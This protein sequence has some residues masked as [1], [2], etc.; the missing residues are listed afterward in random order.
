VA[1]RTPNTSDAL[2]LITV[3]CIAG[4]PFESAG[5][6]AERLYMADWRIERWMAPFHDLL[7]DDK[8]GA[9]TQLLL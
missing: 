9:I 7:F 6:S 5:Q 3:L 8:A 1:T 4:Y 2:G